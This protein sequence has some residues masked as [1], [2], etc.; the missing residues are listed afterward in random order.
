M[1][2]LE[3]TSPVFSNVKAVHSLNCFSLLYF[4]DTKRKLWVKGDF[5]HSNTDVQNRWNDSFLTWLSLSADY[6]GNFI[7]NS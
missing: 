3:K 6:G 1:L 4:Q 5:F 7:Q 2:S